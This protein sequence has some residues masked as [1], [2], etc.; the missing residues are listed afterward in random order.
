MLLNITHVTKYEY[1]TPVEYALQKVRLR[2]QSSAL[3]DVELWDLKI[4][5]GRIEAS[6]LDHFDNTVDLVSADTGT[7]SLTLTASGT[8]DTQEAAGILGKGVGRAPL[9][10][11]RQPIGATKA[12]DGVAKLATIL[13]E[14]KDPLKGFHN[15]STAIL[16]N[17]PY[18]IGHTDASTTAEDAIKIGKGV[19]QDHANIFI[20][21]ARNAGF[22]ARYVSGY[23]F[24]PD[25]E[26][27][28]AS[29]AWAEVYLDDLGWVGFDVSNG[30]SPDEKYLRIAVGR[31]AWE[32]AP[33]SGLRHG[34]GKE[35]MIVSLQVQ[36]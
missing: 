8:A 30:I 29:H 27:Q 25:R 13:H 18:E 28:D 7:Q 4:E 17:V 14:A 11:F 19:C 24:M 1:D 32:A 20:A 16:E 31:D 10:L 9:W 34:S 3:Q 26:D 15:L 21:A 35:A 36:Q 33:V 2:P 12:G 22:P 6:Y 23:L 5:G